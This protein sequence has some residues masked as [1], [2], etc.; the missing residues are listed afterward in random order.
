MIKNI[1]KHLRKTRLFPYP[2]IY[3]METMLFDVVY[4]KFCL[5]HNIY[6]CSHLLPCEPLYTF[7][8]EAV[9]I[10]SK[11]EIRIPILDEGFLEYER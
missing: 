6:R 1:V 3:L 2:S 10:F 9:M 7:A 11:H 8:M 5:V 4:D